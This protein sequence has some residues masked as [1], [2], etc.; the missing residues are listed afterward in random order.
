GFQRHRGS[1]QARAA[2]S[3][4]LRRFVD[5]RSRRPRGD[6]QDHGRRLTAAVT[7]R[8]DRR[9]GVLLLMGAAFCWSLGGILNRLVEA[10]DWTI[11]FWRST[12][13]SLTLV[14]VLAV[15]TRGKVLAQFRAAGWH[16]VLLGAFISCAMICFVLSIT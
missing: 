4:C 9:R 5:A 1:D 15:W 14:A 8:I 13:M 10:T 6:R 16:G 7:L 11:V 3:Q 2:R 12:F